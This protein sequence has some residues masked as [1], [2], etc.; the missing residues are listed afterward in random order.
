M[1]NHAPRKGIDACRRCALFRDNVERVP[2]YEGCE[3]VEHY[4]D[5]PTAPADDFEMSL[6]RS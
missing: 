6:T 5:S 2:I 3:G 4:P 1:R